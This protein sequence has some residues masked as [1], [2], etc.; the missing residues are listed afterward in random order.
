MGG[1]G[2]TSRSGR[3]SK[4]LTS[5]EY[6]KYSQ[7]VIYDRDSITRRQAGVL[8]SAYKR[9][10][11][12][13]TKAQMNMTYGR[14]ASY[15]P[16]WTTDSHV[17]DVVAKLQMAVSAAASSDYDAASR[18]FQSYLDAHYAYFDDSIYPDDR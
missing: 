17:S 8:Y 4:G 10:D 6:E 11:L 5:E 16:Q 2:S 18:A 13:A 9:G 3:S 7:N 12:D 15:S 1:R 14:Y